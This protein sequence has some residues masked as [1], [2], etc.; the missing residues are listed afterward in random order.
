MS[1]RMHLGSGGVLSDWHIKEFVRITPFVDKLV[2]RGVISYGLSSF[3]YD[4]RVANKFKIA[5]KFEGGMIDPKALDERCFRDETADILIL[6][7]HGFALA[8]TIEHIDMPTNVTAICVGKSTYARCGLI[9]NVTPI[10]A[11][12][13][14]KI[15]LELSNTTDLP[16]KVYANE[17]ICQLVFLQ[18]VHG[19]DPI[20]SYGDRKGKYMDQPGIVLPFVQ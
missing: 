14:G 13:R 3:G 4:I 19:V 17:G 2:S 15:T 5:S 20:T 11:G 12:W 18:G 8:E 16:I 7:P 10:E 9:V 1:Y 6:E